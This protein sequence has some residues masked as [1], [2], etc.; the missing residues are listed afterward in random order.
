MKS[1]SPIQ[2]ERRRRRRPA[3]VN[4]RLRWLHAAQHAPSHSNL[5]SCLFIYICRLSSAFSCCSGHVTRCQ[6]MDHF[7]VGEGRGTSWT[8]SAVF[9]STSPDLQLW[10]STLIPGRSSAAGRQASRSNIFKFD[11]VQLIV[12]FKPI[13][14]SELI[15][16]CPILYKNMVWKIPINRNRN[17]NSVKT[18]SLQ[19]ESVFKFEI[20]EALRR[21]INFLCITWTRFDSFFLFIFNA[22]ASL[23]KS[24]NYNANLDLMLLDYFNLKL[25]FKCQVLNELRQRI[26]FLDST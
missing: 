7:G 21:R 24:V 8:P 9:V 19:P 1:L 11:A 2:M 6:L 15:Q 23:G 13:N 14:N 3:A 4:H 25:I 17:S 26:N 16:H 5:F 10:K 12:A 22:S 20:L 18:D